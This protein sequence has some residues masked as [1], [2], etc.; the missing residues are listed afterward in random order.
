[1]NPT[2]RDSL[3]AWQ[4]SYTDLFFIKNQHDSQRWIMMKRQE[5]APILEFIPIL[6]EFTEITIFRAGDEI[7]R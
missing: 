2:E 7:N 4:V 3:G 5:A 1:L 6:S